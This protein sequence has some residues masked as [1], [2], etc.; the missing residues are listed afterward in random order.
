M[1]GVGE[2]DAHFRSRDCDV[3]GV[4]TPNVNKPPSP[5]PGG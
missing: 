2:T 3:I 4:A 5:S 1:L